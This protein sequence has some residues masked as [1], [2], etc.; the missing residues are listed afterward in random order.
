MMNRKIVVVP[1]VTEK[2][3]CILA[4]PEFIVIRP[5]SKTDSFYITG[6]LRTDMMLKYMYSKT[7]GGTPSRYRLSE[8]DFLTLDFP[9]ATKNDR[10][11][12]SKIFEKALTTYDKTIKKAEKELVN[13]HFE[14]E[15]EL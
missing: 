10:E 6:V 5:H 13:S 1:K 15:K 4:S 2:V 9:I 7:R 12:K 11:E 14:I 3:K 8:D